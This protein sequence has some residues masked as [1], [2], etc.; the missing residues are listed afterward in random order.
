MQVGAAEGATVPT[1]RRHFIANIIEDDL[2][3]GKHKSI[4]T[5]FPPVRLLYT[6]PWDF[7]DK[8]ILIS[9]LSHVTLSTRR[10]VIQLSI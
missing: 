2:R 8:E 4:L 10:E 3:S 9:L 7:V 6:S 1:S 5:R